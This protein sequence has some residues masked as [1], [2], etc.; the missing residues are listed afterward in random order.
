MAGD[1]QTIELFDSQSGGTTTSSDGS[2]S[3]EVELKWLVSQMKGYYEAEQKGLS[4]APLFYSGHRR[5]RLDARGLGHGWY[6]ITA[7]YGDGSINVNSLDNPQGNGFHDVPQHQS[8]AFDTTGATEHI[9]Q[10]WS[11]SLDPN[12]ARVVYGSQLDPQTDNNGLAFQPPDFKGALNVSG[13]SVQGV[14]ITVPA[15]NWTET[16]LMP[17]GA[18]F[19][20]PPNVKGKDND[21]NVV[22]TEQY[23]YVEYLYQLTGCVNK[24]PFRTFTGG[25]VLFLGARCEFNRGMTMASITLSF[26]ARKERTK[27]AVGDVVVAR[28]KGWGFLWIVYESSA[29]TSRVIKKPKYVYVE[30]VYQEKDF[31]PLNIGA[32][33]WPAAYLP[34]LYFEKA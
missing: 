3:R 30:Q 11:D 7:A 16:W 17:A 21:G 25:E 29:D 34:D 8:V 23:S 32:A 9:T 18:L 14:D 27:F 4:L 6:E 2:I 12:S 10:S 28:K 19:Y 20:K 13:D 5:T 22:A 24:T 1:P 33:S 15:F 26:S 31:A